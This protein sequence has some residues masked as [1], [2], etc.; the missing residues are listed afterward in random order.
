ML[1]KGINIETGQ[2]NNSDKKRLK[3]KLKYNE[4][5]DRQSYWI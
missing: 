4:K 2:K 1:L 3:N 5:Y